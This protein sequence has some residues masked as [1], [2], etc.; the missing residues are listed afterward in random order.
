MVGP[1]PVSTCSVGRLKDITDPLSEYRSELVLVLAHMSTCTSVIDLGVI[2]A[3]KILV[4]AE[5]TLWTAM[6]SRLR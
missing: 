5:L 2:L 1:P 3:K 4:A 6:R